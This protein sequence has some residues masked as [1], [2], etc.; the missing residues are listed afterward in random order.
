MYP[1]TCIANGD[2]SE[3]FKFHALIEVT[4]NVIQ[5]ELAGNYIGARN[6]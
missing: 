4:A 2:Y 3:T 5:S 1:I 6:L